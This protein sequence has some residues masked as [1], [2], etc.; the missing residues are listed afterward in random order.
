MCVTSLI[1]LCLFQ[2]VDSLVEV[3]K[4]FEKQLAQYAGHSFQLRTHF[5]EIRKVWE[6]LGDDE[7]MLHIDFSE[8]YAEVYYREPQARH[9]GNDT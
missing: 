4:L 6:T 7:L 3:V 2:K 9:F 8:N 5:R 1:F